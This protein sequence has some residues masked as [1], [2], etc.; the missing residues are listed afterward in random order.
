M[1]AVN[2]AK[3]SGGNVNLKGRSPGME[4]WSRLRSSPIAVLSMSVVG[5]LVLI[6]IFADIIV[7]YEQALTLGA[8]DRLLPPGSPG[9]L[10][11]TDNLGRDMFA[12]II[13]GTRIALIIGLTSATIT[14]VIAT[15]LACVCAM[16]G[17]WVDNV[18]MRLTDILRCVPSIAIALIIVASLGGGIPQL[19]I[20]L[21]FSALPMHINMIRSRALG[22]VNME[23]MES[24]VALGGRRF[25]IIVRH[26]IPN[27]ISIIIVN[28]TAQISM[29]IMIGATLGFI[30]LGVS[31]PTPEWGTMLAEGLRF[32]LRNQY[33]V[34]VPGLVLAGSAL[35]FNTL[36]DC[37]RDAF[38]P[39][40]KGKS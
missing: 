30:G 15:L 11:G 9:H 3:G 13:H 18:I 20:A 31:P 26:M 17:G 29:S 19:I 39:Q 32:M 23:Y 40:L 24:A 37:L 34:V 4:V 22:I 2:V 6:G 16:F 28:G 1:A 8:G 35:F 21:I 10:L 5:A 7:P 25:Y 12:R 36:G 38:D 27:L 14:V 33:M